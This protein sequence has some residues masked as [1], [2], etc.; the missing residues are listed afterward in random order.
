MTQ[1]MKYRPDID[2]LRTVA[3][4]PVVLFHAGLSA[5]SGGFVGVDIFFVISGF[6]ITGIIAKSID[7]NRFSI[8]DFY[9]RR[10]KRIFPSFVLMAFVSTLAAL[11]IFPPDRLL[12][13]ARSLA[14]ASGFLSNLHFWKSIDYFTTNAHVEP[15]LHTW[16]LAVEEQFYIFHPWLL[17]LLFRK[18]NW[19][20]PVLC[21]LFAA[22]LLLSMVTVHYMQS[23]TFYMLPTRAWELLLGGILALGWPRPPA[24]ARIAAT[25]GLAGLALIVFAIFAYTSETLFPGAAALPPTVGAAL[26]IWA[27]MRPSGLSYRLLSSAP[28]VAIGKASYS[29]YLW[30]FPLFAFATY[31]LGGVLP[32]SIG[33]LLSAVALALAFVTLWLVENPVRRSNGPLA[34]AV[35]AILMAVLLVGGI[36]ITRSDGMPG[37]LSPAAQM[38][39]DASFDKNRHHVECMSNGDIIVEPEKACALGTRSVVP[40]VLLWGDSHS[41]VTATAMEAMA[42]RAGASFL[43]AASADCP[44]G[45]GFTISE[46]FASGLTT[47]PSYRFCDDYNRRML[48][49]TLADP[50]ITTVVISA[51]WSNWR[52]GEPAN[53]AESVHDIR[54]MEGGRDARSGAE[55]KAMFERGFGRLIDRLLQAGKHVYLVGPVPEPDFDVP[56]RL[57]IARFGLIDQPEALTRDAFRRRHAAILPILERVAQRPDVTLLYPDSLLCDGRSCPIIRDGR[58]TYLDHNHLSVAAARRT[59]PLYAPLFGPDP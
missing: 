17:L 25:G 51:R 55:N 4:V 30:H 45:L 50:A 58:P 59:A 53:P 43:F 18:R 23:A 2:G 49:R 22:S 5:M 40:H 31:L 54:L 11:A 20:I 41:M 6:L 28:F 26:L 8:V 42:K 13:Y 34:Y 19:L 33:L 56:Y 16:S 47:T 35:P 14:F 32:L 52:I 29:F 57:Y 44:P 46:H 15:L 21:A 24:S 37:R 9:K 12:A 39:V 10:I 3:V 38:I 1:T 48:A 27:G 7:D 36:A